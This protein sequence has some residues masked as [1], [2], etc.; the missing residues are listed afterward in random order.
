MTHFP[1]QWRDFLKID[2]PE[3]DPDVLWSKSNRERSASVC[4]PPGNKVFRVFEMISPEKVRVVILG[5]DPY[6]G[7][8]QANGLAFSVERGVKIPP[9][10]MNMY[11]EVHQEFQCGIPSHGDLSGWA[12]Q[13]VFLLNAIL[14]VSE[15]KPESHR[16]IGWESFTD[17]VIRSISNAGHPVVFMLW[18]NR[19]IAKAQFIDADKH[20]VLKSV[21]PSPLSA[22]RGFL[23]NG[24]FQEA[25]RFLINRGLKPINWCLS[26]QVNMTFD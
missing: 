4:Y 13:G 25:N 21:H 24:H 5:Q 15:G 23:G 18:G 1:D 11:K 3:T 10:L 16:H 20:L 14:T 6:H 12:G 19:A 17:Q 8:G 2:T 7:S 26:D 9:S 22:H